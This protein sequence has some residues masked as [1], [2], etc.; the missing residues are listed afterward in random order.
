M[1]DDEAPVDDFEEETPP[2]EDPEKAAMAAALKKANEQAGKHR[3]EARAAQAELEKVRNASLSDTEKA[4]ALARAEARSEALRETGSRLV[5]A[6]VRAAVAGR[7]VDVAA[8]LEGLDRSRFITDDGEPDTAK[9]GKWVDKIVPPK[10]D[11]VP[12]PR[13]GPRTTGDRPQDMNALIRSRGL[14]G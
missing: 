4:I 6:E 9:I 2:S 10:G 12:P 13:G 7:S 11:S 14:R 5:D 1:A 8:L 3:A